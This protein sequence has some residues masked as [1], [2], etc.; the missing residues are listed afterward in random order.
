VT[1]T[2]PGFDPSTK[3]PGTYLATVFGGAP[4]SPSD[5]P[6][7]TL[8]VGN[9]IGSAI[10]GSNPTLSVAAG[11]AALSTAY[12]L[13]SADD[14][15]AYFGAGSELHRMALVF[16]A[17][18]PAGTCWAIATAQGA[19]AST[20]IITAT[21]TPTA[22]LTAR[23]W[24]N[25]ESVD[26]AIA[27]SDSVTT[28]A[29]NLATAINQQTNWPVTAQFAAGVVT[30]TAKHTG[31]RG[32]NIQFRVSLINST[33][34]VDAV[35]GSL[36]ATLAGSTLT[37]SGG[38]A[39]G[40]SSVGAYVF[41]GGTTEET[42]TAALAAIT[43]VRYQRID[44]AQQTST[45]IVRVANQV[46]TMAGVG[47][48]LR[49]QVVAGCV[50]TYANVVTL[51]NS[52]QRVR[53]S[54][55]WSYDNP[56]GTGELAAGYN[57]GRLTGDAALGGT[58][59]G[60]VQ[61]PNANLDGIRLAATKVPHARSDW[62]TRT[63]MNAALGAGVTPLEPLDT[64]VL[65]I[66]RAVTTRSEDDAGNPNYSVL[67]TSIVTTLDYEADA[68]GALFEAWRAGKKLAPDP[69][70]GTLVKQAGVVTPSGGKGL[71]HGFLKAEET[72]GRVIDVDDPD[73]LAALAVQID[74]GN[75]GRVLANVP[76]RPTPG[77]HQVAAAIRQAP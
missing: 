71:V 72:A 53:V 9:M 19:T 67:D 30:I 70:D 34:T 12:Q 31:V 35:A 18:F 33:Q 6:V 4:T 59:V 13:F 51:A 74:P 66:T 7:K 2:V 21:G 10:T 28:I 60:E 3:L 75:R 48:Q 45:E 39:V 64:G 16:F 20:G 40:T 73:M 47:T 29:T 54:L 42:T 61:D 37:L 15:K 26:V 58:L 76:I 69:A 27:A 43:A 65:R 50:D 5:V 62:P 46:D 25:E 55:G 38:T 49:Q 24:I 8:L 32:K 77:A 41:T 11:T 14:A 23:C 52:L 57:A 63:Q 1:I 56:M 17:I 22:A 68:L 44:L 36:A